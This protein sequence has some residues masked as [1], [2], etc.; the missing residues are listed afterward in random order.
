[1]V[2][3]DF[4]ITSLH[5]TLVLKALK[6]QDSQMPSSGTI[7]EWSLILGKV[8]PKTKLCAHVIP[9]GASRVKAS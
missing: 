9:L 5:R 2:K 7:V 3:I 8:Y 1:M 4:R 6:T